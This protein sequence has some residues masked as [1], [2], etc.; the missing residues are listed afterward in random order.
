MPDIKVFPNVAKILSL[1]NG[2][3]PKAP[4]IAP[5]AE[6]VNV[7]IAIVPKFILS[8]PLETP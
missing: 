6:P 5:Y 3:P 1:R 7:S 2:E 4:A 8:N